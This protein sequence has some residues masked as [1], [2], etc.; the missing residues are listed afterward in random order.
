M[1]LAAVNAKPLPDVID[2]ALPAVK[3]EISKSLLV[4][5]VPVLAK[6]FAAMIKS[7]FDATFPA[8]VTVAPDN[9]IS[10]PVPE[11]ITLPAAAMLSVPLAPVV[12]AIAPP[13][14]EIPALT[15]IIPCVGPVPLS[16]LLTVIEPGDVIA[17]KAILPVVLDKVN[18]LPIKLPAPPPITVPTIDVGVAVTEFVPPL[19]ET[20][21]PAFIATPLTVIC[22]ALLKPR[23]IS[24]TAVKFRPLAPVSDKAAPAVKLD[25]SRS[26]PVLIVPV[27]EKLFAAIIRSRFAAT[28]PALV[29]VLPDNDTSVPVPD[30]TTL[31]LLAI[32]RAP[33]VPVF[34]AI[35]PPVD[36]IAPLA[37]TFPDPL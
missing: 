2:N 11:V 18:E 19:N 25:T 37:V 8:F 22:E 29:N 36:D 20:L 34:K 15:V 30:V 27:L 35:A 13:V 5:I 4:L 26:L 10:V 7:L 3:L 9:D 33:F 23:L 14:D 6:L 16:P 31:P 1:S 32:V 28:F 21:R 12:K 24:L 17:P